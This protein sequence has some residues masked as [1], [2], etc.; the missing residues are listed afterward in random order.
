MV[1]FKCDNCGYEKEV[2]DKYAEIGDRPGWI[3]LVANASVFIP[4]VGWILGIGLGVYISIGVAA[5]FG[6]GVVFGLGLTFLPFVFYPILAFGSAKYLA[7][8]EAPPVQP[9]A[10]PMPPAEPPTQPPTPGE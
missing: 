9:A 10:P 4:F 8:A 2:S 3:G 1:L 6:R 7:V 5:V